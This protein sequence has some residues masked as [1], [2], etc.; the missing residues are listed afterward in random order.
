MTAWCHTAIFAASET[1]FFL[2]VMV[3][4]RVKSLRLCAI[5]HRR[6][7]I[8]ES[9]CGGAQSWH[10]Q[11]RDWEVRKCSHTLMTVSH[12]GGT[13]DSVV[14]ARFSET[15]STGTGKLGRLDVRTYDGLCQYL[16]LEGIAWRDE[17]LWTC[18]PEMTMTEWEWVTWVKGLCDMSARCENA[19]QCTTS[20]GKGRTWYLKTGSYEPVWKIKGMGWVRCA[21][22]VRWW[23]FIAP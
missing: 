11:H 3:R 4:V 13:W 16:P 17:R 15:T 2:G 14:R 1:S 10:D 12:H 21:A 8:G 22:L 7:E 18:E 23:S 19:F 9:N 5:V 6:V 20:T